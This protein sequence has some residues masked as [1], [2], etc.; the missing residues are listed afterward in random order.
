MHITHM[1]YLFDQF[2]CVYVINE[3]CIFCYVDR[4]LFHFHMRVVLRASSMNGTRGR[5]IRILNLISTETS[6]VYY[7]TT[8][9][10]S[11]LTRKSNFFCNKSS[12]VSAHTH[13]Y[14]NSNTNNRIISKILLTFMRLMHYIVI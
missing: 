9:V 1:K 14:E 4:T 2:L 11:Y 8:C 7:L 13:T 10:N 6:I 12:P 5:F 3:I